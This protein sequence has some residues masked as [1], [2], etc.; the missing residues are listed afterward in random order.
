MK[1]VGEAFPAAQAIMSWIET[2]AR[3]IVNSKAA[4]PLSWVGPTGFP[5]VQPYRNNRQFRINTLLQSVTVAAVDVKSPIAKQKQ[6]QAASPNVIHCW[7]GAHQQLTAIECAEEDVDMAGVHDSYWSHAATMDDLHAIL[8]R[9]F[10]LMHQADLVMD[11]YTQWKG[12]Y[13]R[14][15]LPLPPSKGTLDLEL[16]NDSPYFFH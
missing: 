11:L 16:V 7:D 9:Q 15:E 12:R 6:I 14:V 4:Q 13:P 3:K 8:R 2:C 1:S 10:V 5:V